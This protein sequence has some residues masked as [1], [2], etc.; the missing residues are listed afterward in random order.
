MKSTFKALLIE[1]P[2]P[3]FTVALP[4]HAQIF[5]IHKG[6]GVYGNSFQMCYHHDADE[7]AS[8]KITF[9]LVKEGQTIENRDKLRYI[10]KYNV[11]FS[12][13]LV[14]VYQQVVP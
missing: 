1:N 13:G 10:G 8:E 5:D 4:R 14:F 11:K 3:V 9:F 2:T 6:Q 12:E 7:I